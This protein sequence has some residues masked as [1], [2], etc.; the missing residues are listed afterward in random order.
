[1]QNMLHY[2]FLQKLAANKDTPVTLFTPKANNIFTKLSWNVT[3]R[4]GLT[5][6]VEALKTNNTDK[7]YANIIFDGRSIQKIGPKDRLFAP[8]AMDLYESA[9]QNIR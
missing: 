6:T 7:Y 1:M 9:A 2:S 4:N 5:Y 8:A 3:L